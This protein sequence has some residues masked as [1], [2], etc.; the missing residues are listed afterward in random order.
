MMLPNELGSILTNLARRAI[1]YFLVHRTYLPVPRDLFRELYEQKA[2]V[3]ICL[4]I[5]GQLRGCIG[6]FHPQHDHLIA[7]IIYN[8]VSAAVEDPRFPPVTLKDLPDIHITVDIL[9]PPESIDSPD[10]LDPKRYG[11]IVQRGWRRGLLLP[12]IE[13]VDS[14]QEQIRIARAKAGI[15]PN[16]PVELF[17]FRVERYSELENYEENHRDRKSVV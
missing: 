13:G 14:I 11:V 1:E 6:T 4:K 2:G 5:H 12:D 3:F 8:A 7:E 17:R 15:K 16:E 10:Q 9:T